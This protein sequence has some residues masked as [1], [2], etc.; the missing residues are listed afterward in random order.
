R[1]APAEYLD[2]G[3]A[4]SDQPFDEGQDAARTAEDPRGPA[5]DPVG[6]DRQPQ[7]TA[8]PY[9]PARGDESGVVVDPSDEYDP[10]LAMGQTPPPVEPPEEDAGSSGYGR[11][12]YR[13]TRGIGDPGPRVESAD[14]YNQARATGNPGPAVGEDA[15]YSHE[16]RGTGNP[17][18]P[19]G[20]DAEYSH[21]QRGT[22]NPGPE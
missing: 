9:T 14:E 17:G 22:G 18:P 20:E 10:K 5:A 7:T 16:Q 11:D 2:P 12:E 4:D 21:E 3:A 6:G 15:G 13:R 1:P 8:D 19:V